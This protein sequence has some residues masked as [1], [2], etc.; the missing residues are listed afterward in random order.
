MTM[1]SLIGLSPSDATALLKT[2]HLKAAVLALR[3]RGRGLPR[4]VGQF[5]AAGAPAPQ[6]QLVRLGLAR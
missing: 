3:N 6:N 1:P 2:M 4:V 5:P